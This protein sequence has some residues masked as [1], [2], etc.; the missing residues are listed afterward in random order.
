MNRY[1]KRNKHKS[2]DRRSAHQIHQLLIPV[3]TEMTIIAP[4]IVQK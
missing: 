2:T 1:Q 4:K 3:N